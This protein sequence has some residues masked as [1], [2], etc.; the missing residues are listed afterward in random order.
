MSCL[1]CRAFMH[2]TS[3]T[4]SDC[5]AIAVSSNRRNHVQ[6]RKPS[7]EDWTTPIFFSAAPQ[8]FAPF[9]NQLQTASCI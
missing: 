2:Q 3:P 1:W 8:E 6:D 4:P 9:S 5:Q 7:I